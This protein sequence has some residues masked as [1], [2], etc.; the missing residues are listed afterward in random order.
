MVTVIPRNVLVKTAVYLQDHDLVSRG[1]LDAAGTAGPVISLART[2]QERRE[3]I[4]DR[5]VVIGSAFVLAPFHAGAF[6]KA[7][8]AAFNIPADF[9]KLSYKELTS[10]QA[11]QKGLARLAQ[12]RKHA[13][14][15]PAIPL[16]TLRQNV[17]RAKTHMFIPDLMMECL[18]FGGVGWI[19]NIVS[20]LY[21][22]KNRFSGELKTTSKRNLDA[23]YEKEKGYA[24]NERLRLIA[25]L[26]MSFGLPLGI[27]L[28]L[29]KAMLAP[30]GASP[31]LNWARS[32]AHYFDYKD[33]YWMSLPSMGIVV[34]MQFAGHLLSARNPRELKENFLRETMMNAIFFW[35]NAAWMWAFSRLLFKPFG[36]PVETSVR[37]LM[38]KSPLARQKRNAL[39][40]SLSYL[41][42]FVLNSASL[43]GSIYLN[44]Y[45]TRE[46]VQADVKN[47]QPLTTS[48]LFSTAKPTGSSLRWKGKKV[49]PVV[50]T[51]C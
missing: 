13:V 40:G 36:V 33:G 3:K 32:K 12:A 6:M 15:I 19:T 7:M 23:L 26:A 5:T 35:G 34:A 22:G 48:K 43:A 1:I 11:L 46:R 30:N 4:I 27:G 31:V 21:T 20:R 38:E 17:V 39:I 10:T 49:K 45:L 25:T 24:K 18:I 42:G 16:E 28:L 14:I 9:M 47:L 2:P 51:A 29:K 50:K 41:C 44:N 8:A 37:K